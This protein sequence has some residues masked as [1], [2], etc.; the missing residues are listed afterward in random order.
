M[1]SATF[2]KL[3]K[4][5][6]K[7]LLFLA[8]TGFLLAAS[9]M[10]HFDDLLK[11][12][13]AP[14]GIV[15]FELASSLDDSTQILNT[16]KATEGAMQSAEWSLWFDYIFII[17][18]TYCDIYSHHSFCRIVNDIAVGHG[19]I[20]DD[21]QFILRSGQLRSEDFDFLDHAVGGGLVLHAVHDDVGP[22][23]GKRQGRGLADVA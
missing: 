5:S 20:R 21:S 17:T 14:Y 3:S 16:W 13:L 4:A 9:C 10:L 1:L 2:Q 23:G 12:E 15:S 22:V 11:N 19:P 18:Y 6:E 8:I 7:K